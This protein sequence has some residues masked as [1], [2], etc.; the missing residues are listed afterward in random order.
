MLVPD[1]V[2]VYKRGWAAT[3]QEATRLVGERAPVDLCGLSLGAL[4]ALAAASSRPEDVRRL[5]VCAGFARLPPTVR[6]RVRAIA[7]AARVVPKSL[8]HRQLVADLREPYRSRALAEIAPLGP[9]HLS[10]LMREAASFQLETGRISA[11]TLVLCGDRDKANLPLAS[12]LAEA[13]PNATLG[14][15]PDARHVA[16]LDNPT[17][18]TSLLAEFFSAPH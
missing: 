14:L 16:N 4:A 17:T 15:I 11:P 10:R 18:F 2:P 8:L 3:V 1:L 6:L 9:R 12:T 5:A 13:L 7:L